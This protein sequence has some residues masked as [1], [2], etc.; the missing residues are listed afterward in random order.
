RSFNEA[1]LSSLPVGT[2]EDFRAIGSQIIEINKARPKLAPPE[3]EKR[4]GAFYFATIRD[5]TDYTAVRLRF[6][7]RRTQ[8]LKCGRISYDAAAPRKSARM[9]FESV[10]LDHEECKEFLKTQLREREVLVY[11]HGFR[12]QFFQAAEQAATL[13]ELFRGTKDVLLW[14]WASRGEA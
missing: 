10:L 2:A 12:N 3:A 13:S 14:S 11:V 8:R 5:A 9:R 6:G 1:W 7:D 4:S